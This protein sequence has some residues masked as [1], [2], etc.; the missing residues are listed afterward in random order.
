ME[1]ISIKIGVISLLK[2]RDQYRERIILKGKNL[3]EM[4]EAINVFFQ[5]NEVDRNL[6]RIDVNP[7]V[8]D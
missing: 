5:Q 2:I 1:Q 7:L 3:Q 6:I 8:L 4:R